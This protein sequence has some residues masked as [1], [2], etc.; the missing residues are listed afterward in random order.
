MHTRMPLIHILLCRH[1]YILCV[2]IVF[3]IQFRFDIFFI[4]I[5][6]LKLYSLKN[7]FYIL[8]MDYKMNFMNVPI[9][10]KIRF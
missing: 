9:Y 10:L 5:Y 1:V 6:L 2:C 8:K 7:I 3:L 4:R